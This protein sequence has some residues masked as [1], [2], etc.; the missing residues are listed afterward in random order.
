MADTTKPPRRR[1]LPDLASVRNN[2]QHN[3]RDCCQ[4]SFWDNAR[5]L[6]ASACV[7]CFGRNHHKVGTCARGYLWDDKR[8]VFV[9]QSA[10]GTINTRKGN[11]APVCFK[12]NLGNMCTDRNSR[13]IADTHICFGCGSSGHMAQ[14]CCYAHLL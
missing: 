6:S 5:P 14:A 8:Q 2:N 3:K 13:H 11:C 7:I 9:K 12:Y 1:H 10:G 4:Q